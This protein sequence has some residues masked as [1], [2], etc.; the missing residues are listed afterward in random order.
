M[1]YITL[2]YNYTS[3]IKDAYMIN[4]DATGTCHC[5]NIQTELQS[6]PFCR[7]YSTTLIEVPSPQEREQIKKK[8]YIKLY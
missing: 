6:K 8:Q 4:L 3:E 7:Y 2:I 5:L 1:R